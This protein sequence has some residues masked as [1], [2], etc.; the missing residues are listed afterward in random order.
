MKPYTKIYIYIHS[1]YYE[2]QSKA[3][4]FFLY[5]QDNMDFILVMKF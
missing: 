2:I 1:F 4:S 5:A 3:T